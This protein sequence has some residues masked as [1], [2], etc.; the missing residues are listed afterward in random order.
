MTKDPRAYQQM[1]MTRAFAD[2]NDLNLRKQVHDLYSVP[3]HDFSQWVLERIA[4][5]GTE[6]V[7]DLGS[8]PG[9][10]IEALKQYIPESQYIGV[11]LSLGMLKAC[12]RRYEVGLSLANAENLPFP[13]HVFDVVL[14]NHM[15]HHIPNLDQA[16]SEIWRILRPNG[17]LI[18]ATNSEQTMPE[19]NT[20]VQRAFRLLGYHVDSEESIEQRVIT[21]FSLETG[22]VKLARHF[23]AVARFDLPSL[24]VFPEARPIIEYIN[25]CRPFY[26][27]YIPHGV[28]WEDFMA[29]MSEQ[30]KRL[31]DHF[32]ELAINKLSGVLLATDKGGF[33]MEYLRRLD[34][35]SSL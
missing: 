28:V 19:F 1:L 12:Q 30:L 4:W 22:T 34:E 26:E 14:A 16:L 21:A 15:L 33:A 8:G 11:D 35:T 7:L 31:V 6:M 17:L 25:S 29:I 24:L 32:G 2:E 27:P 13:D 9:N 23:N 5:R 10:Y 3:A 20:L 18:A